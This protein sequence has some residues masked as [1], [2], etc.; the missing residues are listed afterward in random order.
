[1]SSGTILATCS[2]AWLSV[3]TRAG[4]FPREARV[5]LSSASLVT[6]ETAPASRISRMVCCCGRIKRP[7]GAALSMGTTRTARSEGFK[8]SPTIRSLV[9]SAGTREAIR[10]F[11]SWMLSR[12]AAL[13]WMTGRAYLV[14][15]CFMAARAA[16]SS[17]SG[18]R[19]A[20]FRT[21]IQG[22][23]FACIV[24]KMS[25]SSRV[26]PAVPSTTSTAMSVLFSI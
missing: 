12:E 3:M 7:F 21:T 23:D 9:S 4:R 18:I 8:R 5:S 26:I 25:S 10:S 2:N 13:A 17:G 19:S 15:R 20:L 14:R 6:T 22:M 1:M 11:S 16:G 24:S